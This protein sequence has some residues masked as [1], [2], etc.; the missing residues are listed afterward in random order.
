MRQQPPGVSVQ[1]EEI[2]HQ[3][4]GLGHELNGQ[5]RSHRHCWESFEHS[6]GEKEKKEKETQFGPKSDLTQNQHP[7]K[8]LPESGGNLAEV[9]SEVEE[10]CLR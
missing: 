9:M 2:S 6:V 1:G 5:A 8:N 4:K 7:T 3:L 10:W